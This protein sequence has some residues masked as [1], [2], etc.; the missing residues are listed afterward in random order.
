MPSFICSMASSMCSILYFIYLCRLSCVAYQLLCLSC[1]LLYVLC[2]LS[3]LLY[4]HSC[5]LYQHSCLLW[6]FLCIC[7]VICA[8]Y[9][10]IH[11][12]V[13]IFM[14]VMLRVSLY[15]ASSFLFSC[16]L[17]SIFVTSGFVYII[18]QWTNLCYAKIQDR[19]T[20]LTKE[21]SSPASSLCS[22]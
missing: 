15:V 2:Q 1:H 5:L 21:L 18:C 16:Y 22:T 7:F 4:Q 9:A 17:L 11:A 19:F 6:Q 12:C 8:W 10:N 3:C 13:L 20:Q 14:H